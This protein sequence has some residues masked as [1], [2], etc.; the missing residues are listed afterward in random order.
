[1]TSQKGVGTRASPGPGT[2]EHKDRSGDDAGK[3]PRPVTGRP[4]GLPGPEDPGAAVH[5][6][7]HP[8]RVRTPSSPAPGRHPRAGRPLRASTDS[9]PGLPAPQ[10]PQPR[11]DS[12]ARRPPGPLLSGQRDPPIGA[13]G[14]ALGRWILAPHTHRASLP[15]FAA[16]ADWLQYRTPK[17]NQRLQPPPPPPLPLPRKMANLNKGE[18]GLPPT[19]FAQAPS[20]PRP[21]TPANLAPPPAGALRRRPGGHTHFLDWTPPSGGARRRRLPGTPSSSSQA[22][23]RA[24]H[25]AGASTPSSFPTVHPFLSGHWGTPP[26]AERASA[27]PLKPG[28]ASWYAR[29]S[30][31]GR[32]RSLPPEILRLLPQRARSARQL[33]RLASAPFRGGGR[34]LESVR[35]KALAG[36]APRRGSPVASR[37]PRFRLKPLPARRRACRRPVPLQVKEKKSGEVA[38]LKRDGRYIYYLIT[39]KRASHKPTYENL[40]KSLEAMKSHCL[41]NGVT[42]LS[43]P[44]IGCGLD[45]L[46]WENVSVIIEEVFEA[47]DIKITVYTL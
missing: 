35:A 25:Y 32:L 3:P 40:R 33:E 18:S 34:H 47:T 37:L 16:R 21:I 31:G 13:L 42:D 43:M 7:P 5:R 9:E 17:P 41:K 19:A 22:P 20:R 39:K 14:P 11:L 1:M 29:Q 28:S 6:H 36:L 45:R 2:W 8:Q 24:V 26:G 4:P 30:G 12:R 27:P 46:Q 15:R 38:V 10:L 23:P 44:R